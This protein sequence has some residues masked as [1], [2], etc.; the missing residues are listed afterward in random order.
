MQELDG[1]LPGKTSRIGVILRT[2]LLE[3][4]VPGSG[5]RIEGEL[6]AGS[7]KLLLHLRDRLSRLERVILRKVAEVCGVRTTIVKSGV[8]GIIG[9]DCNGLLSLGY[10]QVQRVGTTHRKA[11]DGELAATFRHVGRG[12]LL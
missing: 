10:G 3:E 12:M 1:S 2:I 11:D 5:I 4:P 6:L 9:H 7:F 8:G